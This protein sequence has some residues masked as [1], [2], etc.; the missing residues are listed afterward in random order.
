LRYFEA[1]DLC[2][3]CH[4]EFADHN[5]VE[6]SIDVYLC[7]ELATVGTGYGRFKGGDP[8]LFTPDPEC[9]SPAEIQ[10][11]REACE[12][13]PLWKPPAER[14]GVHNGGFGIGVYVLVEQT[15]FK[16]LDQPD[17]AQLELF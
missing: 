8:N 9:S 2:E 15:T 6:N 17:P 7:P 1:T 16:R 13:W 4:C 11:W 12:M 3:H 10:R 5:Y 14:C